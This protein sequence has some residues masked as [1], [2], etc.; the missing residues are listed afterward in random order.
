MRAEDDTV[1][2][3]SQGGYVSVQSQHYERVDASVFRGR[4]I[5][6]LRYQPDYL[7]ELDGNFLGFW[8][9]PAAGINGAQK[10]IAN[11]DEMAA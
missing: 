3:F 10:H 8:R 7:V 1:S 11:T 2:R 6:V 5:T 4:D 9:T